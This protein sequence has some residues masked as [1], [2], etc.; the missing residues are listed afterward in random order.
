MKKYTE[1]EL[2]LTYSLFMFEESHEIS[3]EDFNDLLNGVTGLNRSKVSLQLLLKQFDYISK[4]HNDLFYGEDY[5]E[6]IR[7]KNKYLT[8]SNKKNLRELFD[9]LINGDYIRQDSKKKLLEK[10]RLYDF[11]LMENLQNAINSNDVPSKD[12]SYVNRYNR[13]AQNAS[14]AINRAGFN[15]EINTDH[16]SFISKKTKKNYVE[17]H[18]II[19][20]SA[21]DYFNVSLDVPENIVA[22]C[23]TC[24]N[25]LHYGKNIT[26]K[27]REIYRKR[28]KALKRKG[29]D[30]SFNDL[31]KYYM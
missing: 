9:N 24:H 15:C 11:N 31:L 19:P 29:I 26:N 23:S 10:D 7:L 4:S 30:I 8:P 21:Q 20:L 3:L 2:I 18:H 14:I 27:F 13:S 12:E 25:E 1:D 22:L 28:K 17:A 6:L 16:R 5:K